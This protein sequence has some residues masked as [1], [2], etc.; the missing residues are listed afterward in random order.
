MSKTVFFT[1]G[2]LK[3]EKTLLLQHLLYI[4]IPL[5]AAQSWFSPRR[6]LGI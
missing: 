4:H 1:L 3:V 6:A 2:L 5:A